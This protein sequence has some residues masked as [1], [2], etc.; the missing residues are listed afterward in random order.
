MRLTRF[1]TFKT[2]GLVQNCLNGRQK[3]IVAF[4]HLCSFRPFTQNHEE[5]V[6][7]K[8]VQ[9]FCEYLIDYASLWHFEFFEKISLVAEQSQ[10]SYARAYPQLVANLENSLHA[11]LDFNDKYQVNRELNELEKDL[12]GLAEKMAQRLEWEDKLLSS[13]TWA[14]AWPLKTLKSA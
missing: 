10:H 12:S 5:F 6:T 13:Y 7:V 8:A 2:D 3:W 11:I 9:E 14:R 4:H 1:S